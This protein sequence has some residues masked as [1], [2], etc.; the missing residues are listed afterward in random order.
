MEQNQSLL[1]WMN[2]KDVVVNISNG[3]NST[4]VSFYSSD[5]SIEKVFKTLAYSMVVVFSVI[6]NSLTIAAFKLNTYGKLRTVNNMF[7]VSMAAA[8]LLITLGSIPERITRIL[9]SEQWIIQGNAGI[10][11]CKITNYVEKLCMNV[12]ILHL[13]MIATDRFLVVF[14]PRRK[15]ITSKRAL[16][17]IIIT[18]F[19][20]AGYCVPLF[21][22]ANLL[23]KNENLFCKTRTFFH[24]WRVWYLLFLSLLVLTLLV[25]V[26]LYAAIAIRLYRRKTPGVRMSFRS[27]RAARL[28]KRVLKMVALIVFTFYCCFL[29]Y[30]IGW[31]FCSYYYNDTICSDTYV[32]V[33]IFLI[34]GNSAVNPIIYS[35]LNHNF[36]DS[37]RFIF[38][39]LCKCCLPR[40]ETIFL[41]TECHEKYIARKGSVHCLDGNGIAIQG[42]TINRMGSWIYQQGTQSIAQES[43]FTLTW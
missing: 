27:R 23:E 16:R 29:P 25:V 39:K 19:A 36:R 24:N 28:N 4:L 18:W 40:R 22:Y 12:A 21:Y 6:G 42:K 17:M 9:V 35:S 38:K 10:F 5:L 15:L 13:A 14:Y 11:F 30:W 31:V 8:D 1:N 7:I 37:F 41:S 33:A 26:V 43:T 32:F 20:S 3:E 2:Q 34:Y